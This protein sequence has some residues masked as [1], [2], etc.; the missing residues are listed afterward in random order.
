MT[1]TILTQGERVAQR[2]MA[3]DTR[4]ALRMG[5]SLDEFRE[6]RDKAVGDWCDWLHAEMDRVHASDVTEILPQILVRVEQRCITEAHRA[7]ETA[8]RNMVATILRKAIT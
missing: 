6:K 3:R 8:A 1:G 4:V 7:G 2:E 5:L